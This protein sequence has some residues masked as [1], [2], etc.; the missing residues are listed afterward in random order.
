MHTRPGP[1]FGFGELGILIF[2]AALVIAL[3]RVE[4]DMAGA[5]YWLDY[6]SDPGYFCEG[7]MDHAE[8]F[9]REPSNTWGCFSFL[10][11]GLWICLV[12]IR[13]VVL[14]NSLYAVAC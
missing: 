1:V 10:G 6:E 11:V 13:Y 9:L 12:G 8:D 7:L 3:R 5:R 14:C 4:L 2:L